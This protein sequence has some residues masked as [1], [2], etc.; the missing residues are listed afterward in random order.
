MD[1]CV[2]PLSDQRRESDKS[3]RRLDTVC[4]NDCILSNKTF[5][6]RNDKGSAECHARMR[7][8]LTLGSTD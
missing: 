8:A 2:T 6:N 5:F 7:D 1:E 3:P 4:S